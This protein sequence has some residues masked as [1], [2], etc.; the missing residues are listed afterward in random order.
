[1]GSIG[2]TN[3]NSVN[4]NRQETL[5]DVIANIQA[6]YTNPVEVNSYDIEDRA[7][8]RGYSSAEDMV[9][10]DFTESNSFFTRDEDMVEFAEDMGYT[11]VSSPNGES[12]TVMDDRD[13]TDSEFI[14]EYEIAGSSRYIRRVRK[15]F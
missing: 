13:D 14:V 1:M 12:F 6:S 11:V 8:E 4:E 9:E 15:G 5:Q 2:A 10:E 3:N 7:L